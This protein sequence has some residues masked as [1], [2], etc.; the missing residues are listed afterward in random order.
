MVISDLSLVH[1]LDNFMAS[2]ATN[3]IIGLLLSRL[4]HI[5]AM[6]SIY[7][8]NKRV[9][10]QPVLEARSTLLSGDARNIWESE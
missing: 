10:P 4:V 3:Q 7:Y 5:E 1:S 6:E 9:S 8:G 2:D